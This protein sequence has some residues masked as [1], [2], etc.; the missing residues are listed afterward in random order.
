MTLLA[1]GDCLAESSV[2]LYSKFDMIL[3]HV[4]K[5]RGCVNTMNT[6]QS[7]T[8][9]PFKRRGPRFWLSCL[10]L[11]AGLPLLVYYGY[12]WGIWGR[13]SLLLQYLFQC[14]CPPASEEARY[15]DEV[16]VIV[17]ACHTVNTFIKLSPSGRFLYMRK[18]ENGL[19]AAD[20][21]DL[22]TREGINVTDQSFSTF[23]TDKLWFIEGGVK[24]Y[25]V[26][27]TNG[28]Q[29]PITTFR[30]WQENAY[31]NGTPNLELLVSALQQAQQVI[32]TQNNDTVVVLMSEFPKNLEQNF[33]FD[34]SDI[35]GGDANKVEL[36]LQ[37][38]NFAYQT[39]LADFPH[40]VFSPDGKLIAR[41]D[42]IYFAETNQMIVKAPTS[43]VRGW[44]YDGL[45]VIYFSASHC[46]FP[47][48]MP[49]A[50]ETACFRRVPQPVLLLNV[51][52]E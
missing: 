9:N 17:P 51:P 48:S 4:M 32:L 52:D 45:S 15:P 50:D 21:L 29:Y 33:T 49:F 34:R 12:C 18:E 36:F 22:Q 24:S 31:I 2:C 8:K 5:F 7:E 11:L 13:Q 26:D 27:V 42:G 28:T 19:A 47:I 46:L 25:I 37:E 23:L 14:N 43:L 3:L 38:N 30:H 20:L 6:L 1:V 10:V 39:V 16:D 44:T 41:D 40:E 35:P